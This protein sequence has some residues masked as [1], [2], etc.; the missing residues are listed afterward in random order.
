VYEQQ[1]HVKCTCSFVRELRR[2]RLAR[3]SHMGPWVLAGLCTSASCHQGMHLVP[4]RQSRPVQR[5]DAGEVQGG[6]CPNFPE[7]PF[8]GKGTKQRPLPTFQSR[9][10]DAG[11]IEVAA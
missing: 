3:R 6:W 2:V 5:G 8:V 1:Q 10:D 4:R 7:L 9:V 11:N